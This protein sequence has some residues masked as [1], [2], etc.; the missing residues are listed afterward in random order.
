MIEPCRFRLG[1][2]YGACTDEVRVE[3][4]GK[5]S[6]I[7]WRHRDAVNSIRS[8]TAMGAYRLARPLPRWLDRIG[9]GTA[10]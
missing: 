1:E 8:N 3:R 10:R 6:P 4:R 7:T 9:N 2:R 5:S